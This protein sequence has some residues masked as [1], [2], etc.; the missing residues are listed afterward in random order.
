MQPEHGQAWALARLPLSRFWYRDSDDGDAPAASAL[1][2]FED[3][4]PLGPP[5]APHDE[6]RARGGGAFSHWNHQLWFSTRDGTDP[7]RNGRRYTIAAPLRLPT[8]WPWAALLLLGAAVAAPSLGWLRRP[9]DPLP[10]LARRGGAL[11]VAAAALLALALAALHALAPTIEQQ[12]PAS[13]PGPI[14]LFGIRRPWR[15]PPFCDGRWPERVTGEGALDGVVR[16]DLPVVPGPGAWIVVGLLLATGQFVRQ[17]PRWLQPRTPAG[18]G[19]LLLLLGLVPAA[20]LA[21]AANLAGTLASPLRAPLEALPHPPSFGPRD[22]PLEWRQVE[23]QLARRPGEAADDFVRRLTL[24]VAD[25]TAHAWDRR[26]ARTLRMQVPARENWLLWL[27]GEIDPQQREYFFV[28]ARRTLERGIGMCG[29]FAHA[30]GELLAEAGF[31]ARLVQLGGHTVVGVDVD[32]A[33]WLLDPDYRVVLPF[34]LDVLAADPTMAIPAYAA[35]LAH[36]GIAD[37]DARAAR[38]AALCDAAGNR[39]SS[40]RPVEDLSPASRRQE[41]L[42]YALRWPLPLAVLAAFALALATRRRASCARPAAG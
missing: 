3:G 15:I 25:G 14:D 13:G 23:P 27:A 24:L 7:R 12:V 35:A 17:A 11:G 33:P 10:R 20:A 4:E 34:G 31:D 41:A 5:H 8:A 16:F 19:G 30:L 42:A 32:G 39:T 26:H 28:D 21:T 40:G 29:H 1:A 36:H 6:I 37:A 38:V 22:R 9:G 18:A 2:L